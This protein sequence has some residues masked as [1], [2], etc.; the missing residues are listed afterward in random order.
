MPM[1]VWGSGGT[2]AVSTPNRTG[3]IAS[4]PVLG[5]PLR[6]AHMFTTQTSAIPESANED[7]L[8]ALRSRVKVLEVQLEA[9][10]S[11]FALQEAALASATIA[12]QQQHPP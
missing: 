8:T 2:Q 3:G 9:A 1:A 10:E 11:S 7:E 4:T 5:T 12:Q 6:H